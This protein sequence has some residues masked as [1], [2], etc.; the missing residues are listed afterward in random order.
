LGLAIIR[1]IADAHGAIVGVQ[2]N[3]PQRNSFFLK[4]PIMET[5]NSGNRTQSS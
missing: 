3:P 1:K 5:S 4:F 2:P